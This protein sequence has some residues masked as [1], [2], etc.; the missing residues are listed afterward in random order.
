MKLKFDPEIIEWFENWSREFEWDEG[1]LQKN[2]KHGI[3]SSKIEN[4]FNWHIYIAGKIEE[5]GTERRWLLLGELK[6]K[7]WALVVTT[8]EEKL[9]IISCRRQRKKEAEAYESFKKEIQN[10]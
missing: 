4:I 8:R 3:T 2:E 7:G 1:N 6:G 5:V 9:R 10:H